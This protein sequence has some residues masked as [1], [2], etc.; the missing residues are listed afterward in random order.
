M[1]T[2]PSPAF[3]DMTA[4]RF[5]LRVRGQPIGFAYGVENWFRS[6]S[7]LRDRQGMGFSLRDT[8][9]AADLDVRDHYGPSLRD[10]AV[11]TTGCGD[12]Y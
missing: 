9:W 4:D 6:P 5:Q 3:L 12:G 11:G 7:F 2:T 10:M 8:P 1:F